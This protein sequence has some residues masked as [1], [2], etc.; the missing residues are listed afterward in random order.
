[1]IGLERLYICTQLDKTAAAFHWQVQVLIFQS[2]FRALS[3]LSIKQ[4][5]HLFQRGNSHV[6]KQ[7]KI[8]GPLRYIIY[9][10]RGNIIMLI[11]FI[12]VVKIN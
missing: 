11:W 12:F 2:D 9:M 5:Q 3:N 7:K 6:N 10:Q 1:M 8:A 4:D